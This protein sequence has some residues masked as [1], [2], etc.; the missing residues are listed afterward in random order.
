MRSHIKNFILNC[1][2]TDQVSHASQLNF[3]LYQLCMYIINQKNQKDSSQHQPTRVE[4]KEKG[5]RAMAFHCPFLF[6]QVET[7]IHVSFKSSAI[8]SYAK[9]QLGGRKPLEAEKHEKSS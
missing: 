7:T 9:H 6:V 8:G 1:R 3:L 5:K 2:I 4:E